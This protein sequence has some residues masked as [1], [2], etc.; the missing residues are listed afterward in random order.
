MKN[1]K[2]NRFSLLHFFVFSIVL[3]RPS[4][5]LAAS[6]RPSG[7]RHMN[8]EE[9]EMCRSE[10]GRSRRSEEEEERGGGGGGRGG[11]RGR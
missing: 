8:E 11:M 1:E 3:M 10:G 5:V 4:Q 2:T 6:W 7:A 9:E